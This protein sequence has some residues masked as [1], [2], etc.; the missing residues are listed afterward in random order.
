[1]DEIPVREMHHAPMGTRLC[2]L[3]ADAAR[4]D[5][6]LFKK[7]TLEELME[8]AGH[9]ASLATMDFLVSEGVCV[10]ECRVIVL[11]GPGNNGGDGLVLARWLAHSGC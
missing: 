9:S 3:S 1:M 6:E 10:T 2:L 11:C 7:S 4:L 5:Q 8:E